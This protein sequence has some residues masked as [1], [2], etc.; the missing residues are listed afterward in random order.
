MRSVKVPPTSTPIRR[1]PSPSGSW[2]APEQAPAAPRRASGVYR[3]LRSPGQ[4]NRSDVLEAGTQDRLEVG[5]TDLAGRAD[6][7]PL[8]LE[9]AVHERRDVRLAVA[10][11][12][13][14]AGRSGVPHELLERARE[15]IVIVRGD[16]LPREQRGDRAVALGRR[17]L[18]E[19][20]RRRRSHDDGEAMWHE[21]VVTRVARRLPLVL[22]PG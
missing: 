15:R 13:E 14:A 9:R 7:Q 21:A 18:G 1:I 10:E 2:Q 5:R 4:T 17:G 22:E 3:P 8:L 6:Q 19:A 11:L 16:G 12:A 20:E